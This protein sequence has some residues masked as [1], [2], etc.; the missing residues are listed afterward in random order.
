MKRSLFFISL[1]FLAIASCST[2]FDLNKTVSS[3]SEDQSF[4]KQSSSDSCD[5]CDFTVSENLLRKYLKYFSKDKTVDIIRPISESNNILAYYV[6]YADNKGWDLI[7]ADKRMTPVLVSADEGE[8][9]VYFEEES[10][11]SPVT[12]ML[13]SVIDIRK[14]N[15]K[16]ENGI[17][18]FLSPNSKYEKHTPTQLKNIITTKARSN[19]RGLGEGMWIAVD[20]LIV[21]TIISAPRLINTEWAQDSTSITSFYNA[22]TPIKNNKHCPVGCGP[23][24]VGQ[25]LFK[26]IKNNPGQHAIPVSASMQPDG[27]VSFGPLSSEAWELLGFNANYNTTVFLSWLGAPSQMNSTYQPNSTGTPWINDTSMLGNYLN[28]SDG[29]EVSNNSNISLK[30]TFCG[31]IVSSIDNG[32]PLFVVSG[33]HVFLIDFYKRSIFQYVIRYEFDPYHVITDDEYYTFPSW[34]FDWPNDYD[35]NKDTAQFDEYVNMI[36]QIQIKMNWGWGSERTV[37]DPNNQYITYSIYPNSL[38]YNIYSQSRYID[39]NGTLYDS[40]SINLYW[41]VSSDYNYD[42]ALSFVYNFSVK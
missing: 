18:N 32:S 21:D 12:S 40:Q 27:S 20:T 5:I 13:Q 7:S 37:S 33:T 23:V 31:L 3:S 22:F 4:E 30:E 15:S 6:R 36:D 1:S 9:P 38:L 14:S 25:L 17:W 34:R 35:P 29:F 28:F 16:D 11:L 8:L 39:G 41:S 10:T 24:A 26:Y 19:L 42:G 2:K